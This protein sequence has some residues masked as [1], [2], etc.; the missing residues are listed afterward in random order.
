MKASTN[1]TKLNIFSC[2]VH[3]VPK[4]GI[5][6]KSYEAEKGRTAYW[7]HWGNEKSGIIY[8]FILK[9]ITHY[10]IAFFEAL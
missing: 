7:R 1:F 6:G 4:T 10:I 2:F 3:Y 8:I 9:N 5:N